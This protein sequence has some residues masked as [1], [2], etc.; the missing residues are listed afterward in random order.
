MNPTKKFLLGIATAVIASIPMTATAWADHAHFV[1]ITEPRTG[2]TTCQYLAAGH[3]EPAPEHPLH[4]LVHLGSPGT[5]GHGTDVDK[6]A[7]EANRCGVV[8]GR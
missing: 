4:E 7:N 1:V 8:R 5:D 6:S 3:S 2:T